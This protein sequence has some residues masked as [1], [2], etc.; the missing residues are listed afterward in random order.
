MISIRLFSAILYRK[1]L[2]L[3]L[4][5]FSG[6]LQAQTPA[7]L[8]SLSLD[9]LTAI[10]DLKV[11]M[12]NPDQVIKL[13]LR[14]QKLKEVP[15]EIARFKNLQYLDLSKNSIKELPE[16]LGDLNSLQFFAASK[17]NIEGFPP[18]LGKLKNLKSLNLNQN[19]IMLLPP[20]IGNLGNLEYLDLW[21]N[22]LDHFPEELKNLKKLKMMDL[23]VILITDG[24][25]SR[26]QGLL[27][28]T[29]IYFSANCNCKN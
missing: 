29:R 14:K 11:A 7:L 5:L 24:E 4:L 18:E 12:Q 3:L 27:P 21:S 28:N 2:L 9:T 13:V 8:D 20:Q 23:R 10:T 26:I 15:K 22:N 17:N 6:G 19:D 25:Q 16:F 1:N